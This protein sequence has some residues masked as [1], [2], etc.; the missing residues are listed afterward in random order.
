MR[1][2]LATISILVLA[3]S[4]SL[5]A[6]SNRARIAPSMGVSVDRFLYEDEGTT[7]LS[8]RYS[9]LRRRVGTEVGAFF[10]PDALRSRILLLA[11]DLGPA[12]NS[13]GADLK[14]LGK[15][16]FSGLTAIGGQVELHPGLHA[17]GG[18]LFRIGEMSA[19][20]VDLTRHVYLIDHRTQGRWSIGLGLNAMPR[21]KAGQQDSGAAGQ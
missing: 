7:A 2:F 18:L 14:L 17:G 12:Y 6:Q 4:P 11:L 20:R 10:F 13:P 9:D 16:G 5:A 19:I 8:F 15:A 3:P 1:Q 21:R